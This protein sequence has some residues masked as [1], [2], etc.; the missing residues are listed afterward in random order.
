[1]LTDHPQQGR[2][3]L[4]IHRS[5]GVVYVKLRHRHPFVEASADATLYPGLLLSGNALVDDQ[6]EV[7]A[8]D[9]NSLGNN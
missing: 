4:G 2:V 9:F 7:L 3:A 1:L 5:D 8:F 6:G